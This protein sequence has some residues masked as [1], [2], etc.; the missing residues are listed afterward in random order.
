MSESPVT[1]GDQASEELADNAYS[2]FLRQVHENDRMNRTWGSLG[3]GLIGQPS[4]SSFSGL[5]AAI[6]DRLTSQMGYG[7]ASSLAAGVY[8]GVAAGGFNLPVGGGTGSLLGHGLSAAV[9]SSALT[10]GIQNQ[11]FDT[12]GRPDANK[13]GLM[14]RTDLGGLAAQLSGVGAFRNIRT[15]IDA[16]GIASISPEEVKKSVEVLGKHAKAISVLKE[17]Y[18]NADIATL[19]RMAQ[20]VTGMTVG[21][22]NVDTLKAKLQNIDL[23]ARASGMTRDQAFRNTQGLGVLASSILAG[24]M[25]GTPEDHQI[26]G[27]AIGYGVMMSSMN[28]MA[29]G[30]FYDPRFNLKSNEQYQQNQ[31]RNIGL[32]AKENRQV[33]DARALLQL[34]GSELSPDQKTA[35]ES[36]VSKS[37]SATSADEK[38]AADAALDK[39]LDSTGTFFSKSR[40]GLSSEQVSA[41]LNPE[42]AAKF[43]DDLGNDLKA[44]QAMIFQSKEFTESSR[45][46]SGPDSGKLMGEIFTS[47]NPATRK[48]MVE[49]FKND[50]IENFLKDNQNYFKTPV[51]SILSQIKASGNFAGLMS[52]AEAYYGIK[53]DLSAST[54]QDESL[55]AA[56]RLQEQIK[57]YSRGKGILD[58]RGIQGMIYDA[59]EGFFGL[60]AKPMD[61]ATVLQALGGT[62][63]VTTAKG[64]N[65]TA[66]QLQ[67]I[68]GKFQGGE[69]AFMKTI[70]EEGISASNFADLANQLSG[71]V[72]ETHARFLGAMEK[73][74]MGVSISKGDFTLADADAF[75]EGSESL[76]L[77][78]QKV[79]LDKL[80]GGQSTDEQLKSFMQLDTQGRETV[81]GGMAASLEALFLGKDIK[82]HF[83][84]DPGDEDLKNLSRM[85]KLD[86]AGIAETINKSIIE[87]RKSN[88]DSSTTATVKTAN[89]KKI[90]DLH[91]LRERLISGGGDEMAGTLR[92]AN[93]QEV[94]LDLFKNA[95]QVLTQMTSVNPSSAPNP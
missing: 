54:R 12:A 64:G 29:G 76:D 9:V 36:L 77:I 68:A 88:D 27:S 58:G 57:K 95:Q 40:K 20:D 30:A 26:L 18:R 44:R 5:A 89:D 75:K 21:Y 84:T 93:F 86:S 3:L 73:S 87:L 8:Q 1:Q 15:E 14:S 50:D 47:L 83:L 67:S 94:F 6:A 22:D 59:A 28:R 79:Y 71:D 48:K 46:A 69:T 38:R 85:F 31:T 37:T 35:I 82:S 49:A 42:T 4:D 32:L 24:Q 55:G 80:T 33:M 34:H 61:E 16:N 11:L 10:R 90:K 52:D 13:V 65:F 51:S 72:G 62:P 45:F 23:G 53:A 39:Y 25:G 19:M 92:I 60:D 70:A 2:S 91:D 56:Q 78:K 66:T 81:K 41:I 7:S 17:T 43:Q 74:G 63:K